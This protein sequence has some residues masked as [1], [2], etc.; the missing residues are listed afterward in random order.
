MLLALTLPCLY[1]G[2]AFFRLFFCFW[3]R[4]S[5]VVQLIVAVQ[6][7]A[8]LGASFLAAASAFWSRVRFPLGR[9][10]GGGITGF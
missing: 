7:A 8:F 5:V 9:A 1:V 2:N 6:G 4:L 3:P 10:P